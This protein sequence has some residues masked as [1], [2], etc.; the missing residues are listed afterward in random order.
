MHKLQFCGC[1]W[2]V[3]FTF[4]LAPVLGICDAS[5]N[6]PNI[7]PAP[8]S[9]PSS[10]PNLF[11]LYGWNANWNRFAP[12][13]IGGAAVAA[14]TGGS[15]DL[16]YIVADGGTSFGHL[17][18]RNGD[19]MTWGAEED[20]GAGFRTES[21]A[22]VSA[23]G[24]LVVTSV[25]LD[26]SLWAR[27]YDGHSWLAWT[28]L[29][30][31]TGATPA[32]AATGSK[33]HVFV[34]GLDGQLYKV[35][36]TTTGS[37]NT[38]KWQALGGTLT[39]N[40]GPAAISWGGPDGRLD[41]LVRRDDGEALHYTMNDD[42]PGSFEDLAMQMRPPGGAIAS[43][44]LRDLSYF[45]VGNDRAIYQKN[46]VKSESSS[47]KKVVSCGGVT[48]PI[49]V[50]AAPD[51]I[52]LFAVGFDAM[53][54]WHT[55]YGRNFSLKA[56]AIPY[57]CGDDGMACCA[58]SD[59]PINC[60]SSL[61]SVCQSSTNRCVECGRK[62]GE[63]CC[64]LGVSAPECGAAPGMPV[65]ACNVLPDVCVAVTSC[66]HSGE[67]CC[68]Q[69]KC[70]D[71]SHCQ[72]AVATVALGTCVKPTPPVCGAQGAACGTGCC[73]GLACTSGVCAKSPAPPPPPPAGKTCSGQAVGAQTRA[74]PVGL[75]DSNGCYVG[76]ASATANSISEA[77]GC[78]QKEYP[79][80]TVVLS[81]SPRAYQYAQVSPYGTCI[82]T[83]V[84]ATSQSDADT[85]V[86]ATCENCVN[87]I[88][89]TCADFQ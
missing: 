28:S 40:S 34:V 18:H 72:G 70:V 64:N 8:T 69:G 88:N 47:W 23:A 22:A 10:A 50:S 80:D 82:L 27:I 65:V 59:F 9:T 2:L 79:F 67:I 81:G 45:I 6:R 37:W 77:G 14:G 56:G 36:G 83:Q 3:A 71:G 54:L 76:Y 57:C 39:I 52:D 19:G 38:T 12:A 63:P 62:A 53:A 20:L 35:T 41:V 25:K 32:I 87:T 31:T 4:W 24:R 11:P 55:F 30:A 26:N 5:A 51:R 73:S 13:R 42:T 43:L 15:L 49:A 58:P 66:G 29:G 16:L 86:Q 46:W 33:L 1:L 60:L 74:Y 44:G 75:A 17:M 85:C 89:A 21:I 7:H 84:T 48:R 61:Q 68:N 78:V